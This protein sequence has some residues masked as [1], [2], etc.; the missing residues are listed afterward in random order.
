MSDD[1][2]SDM[3]ELDP[4]APH[5]ACPACGTVVDVS[6]IEPLARVACP[7]CG[8]SFRVERSF[9]H[10]VLV[11]TLGI[12]GMGSV[13][14]ARDTRLDRF[15]A[16][17][18]LRKELSANPVEAR[19]LEQEARVTASLNHPN[20]V[21]VYSTGIAH[22]QIYLVMELV[23]HGSLDDLMAEEARVP[24]AQAL[25]TGI[26]V[27]R[28]LQA[29]QERGLIHRDVKP[30][31]ILFANAKTAKIGDFGLAVAAGQNAEGQTEIWGTP[32]YVAPE[33]L[34]NEPEDFR[35]DIFSL[36]ATVFHALAGRPPME[37][38]T[39]SATALRELKSHPP[40]L[41]EVAPEVS[42][43]AARVVDRMIAPQPENRF[44]SYIE[45]LEEMETAYRPFS[46]EVDP[47]KLRRR[48]LVTLL[49]ALAIAAA[50]GVYVVRERHAA[51]ETIAS[52]SKDF[53]Q[54]AV[55]QRC[56]G[57]A[58]QQLISGN[59]DAAAAQFAQLS[60]DARG[61]QPL[62]NWIGL[63]RG[64]AALFQNNA[65]AAREAFEEIERA[66]KFSDATADADLVRFFSETVR[67]MKW[68]S[69]TA[70]DNPVEIRANSP[71]AF[72]FLLAAA[73]EWQ[74]SKFE[75]ATP[76]LERYVKSESTGAFAWVND[77]K[78]LARKFL[79]DYALFA[80]WK[81][82]PQEYEDAVEI[83]AALTRLRASERKLQTRGPVADAMK[84]DEKRLGAERRQT[85]KTEKAQTTASSKLL[86]Q[87]RPGWEAALTQERNAIAL[88]DFAAAL[89]AINGVHLTDGA[90]LEAQT[91]ERRRVQWL[92]EWKTKLISD[93][94]T[95]RFSGAV[96]SLRGVS[97]T[98]ASGANENG[99]TF[100]IPPYGSA[101]VKW[102]E[103][104]PK[105]LLGISAAFIVPNSSDAADRQ[106]LC[107]VFA[108]AT[109][110][111]AEA[112]TLAE[113]AAKLKPEYATQLKLIAR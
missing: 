79:A 46:G 42:A 11:E 17:K 95:G 68:E 106:W 34:N 70:A 61:E 54:L 51:R 111:P 92:V 40:A 91:A 33:R 56:Y 6:E 13:Y 1:T 85:K 16:L 82:Q 48:L 72:A 25:R 15:V 55:L 83:S 30:A 41:R 86:E 110:Q 103:L 24:E 89:A 96:T 62:W 108:S 104:A 71:D 53:E 94:A 59:Y 29:A 88:Y 14:K 43:E 97:Y 44:A 73:K 10:F 105:T 26:Q 109:G 75:A 64:L 36:G 18:L 8:E 50:A 20:V 65:A 76:F 67:A 69:V 74:A 78:P 112:R 12:G 100:R 31:N 60:S 38:E 47:K 77:Y 3:P 80:D 37:G 107:A 39:T 23:D 102:T 84:A 27:A 35:S 90:L 5:Q 19:R 81:K 98:G 32:Y 2:L 63:H 113:A 49:A 4:D 45:L 101:E 99:I 87:K 93:L 58:R 28:G 57:E 22:N 7:S 9:D 66:A 21:Q 52:A